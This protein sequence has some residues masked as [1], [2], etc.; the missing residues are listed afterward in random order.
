MNLS[1]QP[2][3][4]GGMHRSG[5]S[6]TASLFA[7]AGLDLGPELLG[8]CEFNP[9]GHFEDLGFFD[10]H[11]RALVAQGLPSEG[12]TATERAIMPDEFEPEIDDLL[13]ARMERGVAW[14]W[15]EPRTILFLDYW[16][17]RLPPARYVFVVRRP[18]G[19]ADSQIGRAHV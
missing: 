16:R 19:V 13:S 14:G 6:L 18:W 3:L 15:K 7:S 1:D 8:A 10:L 11:C 12:Y 5:T 2:L 17:S 4:I 9:L